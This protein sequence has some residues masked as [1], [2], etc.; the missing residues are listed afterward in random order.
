MRHITRNILAG[1]VLAGVLATLTVGAATGQTPAQAT[2]TNSQGPVTVKAVYITAAYSKANP[3]DRLAGKVDLD[4]NLVIAITLDAHSGDLSRYDF[5]QSVTLRND[6]GQQVSPLR[7][8][9][10]A[11][12]AHHRAG[13]LLFPKAD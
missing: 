11:D 5:V 6:R 13:G 4:R 1:V 9:A 3:G 10:T 7:W 12:G 2:Q 8:I